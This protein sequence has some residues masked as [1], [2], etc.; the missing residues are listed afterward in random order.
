M[1][2]PA[3]GTVEFYALIT[4]LVAAIGVAVFSYL[5]GWRFLFEIIVVVVAALSLSL[6][7]R[8]FFVEVYEVPSGSMESTIEIGDRILSEK[9]SYNFSKPQR[10]DIVTFDS[11]TDE[12]V[13]LVK[14]VIAV[15]GDVVDI[16]NGNLYVNGELQQESYAPD[17]TYELASTYKGKR[18][19]Y[20]YAVPDG[21]MWVMG[22]NRD[23]SQDSRYFGS[24]PIDTI[25]G[26]VFFRYWP[27]TR[28]GPM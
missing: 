16:A 23:N 2:I 21:Q 22:D 7:V 14:R 11:P 17:P 25:T 26:K 3:V 8:T 4:G 20:P 18:I 9:V 1:F 6:V 5:R 27:F 13:I 10:G 15:G 19:T 12:G 24:V 28:F